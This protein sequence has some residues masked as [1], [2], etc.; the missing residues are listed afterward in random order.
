MAAAT[1]AAVVTA[2]TAA[3]KTAGQAMEAALTRWTPA[4]LAQTEAAEMGGVGVGAVVAEIKR[5]IES[6][7]YIATR[8]HQ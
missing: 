4:S 2:T 8:E 7:Y 3:T 5:S 1:A 6:P